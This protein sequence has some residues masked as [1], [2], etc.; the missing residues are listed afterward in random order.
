[1]RKGTSREEVLWPF[2][3]LSV[4]PKPTP[5]SGSNHGVGRTGR[6]TLAAAGG[7]SCST[8]ILASAFYPMWY[9]PKVGNG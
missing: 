2:F 6:L 5:D 8:G 4:P 9:F 3:L 1:M 7:K